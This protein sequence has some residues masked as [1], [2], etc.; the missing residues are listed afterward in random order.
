MT[1]K[2]AESYIH[3]L[4]K[5]G[6]KQNLDNMFFAL[7]K[8]NNPQ[9]KLKVFHVAGTNGKGS[10]CAYLSS[11]LEEAGYKVGLFISPFITEFCERISINGEYIPKPE[12]ARLCERI[13]KTNAQ[14][15]EFEFI[16]AVG[17]CYFAEQKVDYAV[18]EVG[19][20]GRLDATNVFKSSVPVIT[21]IGLDHT[22][23]LGNT[24]DKI[25]QEKC[26]II[27]GETAV[28]SPFQESEVVNFTRNYVKNPVIPDMRDFK[29]L[30]SDLSGNRFEF[31]NEIYETRLI[32]EYQAENA[33]TALTAIDLSGI[34]IP[35][36]ALKQGIKNAYIPARSEIISENPLMILDGAHNP[37]AAK[38]L[39][40]EIKKFGKKAF[41]VVAVMRD[42]DYD[43]LLK[44]ILPFCSGGV[45]TQVP[46]LER[47]LTASELYKTAQK[48]LT[49][50]IYCVPDVK[51]ALK[52]AKEKAEGPIFIFGSLYLAS[53]I[54]NIDSTP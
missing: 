9:D 51:G 37:L 48:Y 12:L 23:I 52:L 50:N 36:E 15:C 21:H 45:F 30:S 53:Y 27:K 32:G 22:A 13:K 24:L 33:V 49:Y 8:L 17:L 28:V 3:S 4:R 25:A 10:V 35:K 43:M 47:A 44:E 11:V 2:E 26:G 7:S 29:V 41:A 18:I 40:A 6:E 5:F 42:K 34:E 54:K 16:T 39:A 20:G 31:R 14:L 19:L 1:F 46:L 38:A